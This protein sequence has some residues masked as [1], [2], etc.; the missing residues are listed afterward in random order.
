ML[1]LIAVAA[2][3]DIGPPAPPARPS[4]VT[5]SRAPTAAPPRDVD[6]V[7]ASRRATTAIDGLV[8]GASVGHVS[9]A[10]LDVATGR[11]FGYAPDTP[12]H[13][14]SVVKL[15][16]LATLLLQSQDAGRG[17]TVE[18]RELATPMIE[19]SDND[20]ATSLW[21]AVGGAPAVAE[22]NRRLG[23]PAMDLADHWGS[24]TTSASD[25][26]TLLAAL[27]NPMVLDPAA[28]SFAHDLMTNVEDD[29]RWGVSAAADP[30]TT[31]ALKNGWVPLDSDDGRWVV[32][33]VGVVTVAGDP[34]R[35]AVLTESQPSQAAGIQLVEALSRIAAGAVTSHPA[36]KA[37]G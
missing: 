35:L 22:A 14:A 17:L 30:G 27:S 36:P 23:P 33:S 15:D 34:V 9:V 19:Q 5:P 11:S 18:E 28:R 13:T 25:Q 16:I 21:N 32:A 8:Q 7:A 6:P 1:G 4:V 20:A 10:A 31:T 24:S 3:H 26:L 2:T 37:V 29:Q 12:I